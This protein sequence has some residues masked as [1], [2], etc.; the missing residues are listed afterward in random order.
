VKLS[1]LSALVVKQRSMKINIIIIL[2]LSS[3]T[4]FDSIAQ[5]NIEI[6]VK[7]PVKI[8]QQ[9]SE[10]SKRTNTIT[11]DFTQLKE[12]SFMEES[13]IASGKFYFQ[14]EKQLRWEYT[15]PFRYAIIL[16]DSRIRIIDEGKSK[17]FDAG[18]DRMFLQISE[19]MTGM[20]N[21]TLLN[22]TLFTATWFEAAGFYRADLVPTEASLKD[23]LSHIE[24]KINKLDY[25]VEELKM[26]EKSGDF[27]AITFRNKKINEPIPAEIFRLD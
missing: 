13:V 20:V 21:G 14:K 6:P 2:I 12:M 5:E 4:I 1:D 8:T 23:Y 16:N 17:E 25:S 27:T 15:A 10:F 24:L 22:S 26:F 11:S 18:S 7:D 3:Q 9:V 19:V